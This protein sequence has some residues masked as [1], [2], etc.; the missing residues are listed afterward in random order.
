MG[1][2]DEHG[3]I[4][5]RLYDIIIRPHIIDE[6]RAEVESVLADNGGELNVKALSELKYM[7]SVMKESQRFNPGTF[8][9]SKHCPSMHAAST[10]MR[11]HTHSA[12]RPLGG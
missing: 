10:H 4:S 11:A 12:V 1:R 3:L 6:I 9:M 2:P 8:S 7:D 5:S